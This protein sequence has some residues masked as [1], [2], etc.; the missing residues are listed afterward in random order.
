MPY[1]KFFSAPQFQNHYYRGYGNIYDNS[2]P[3]LTEAFF[4]YLW[5]ATCLFQ[6]E[7]NFLKKKRLLIHI[8]TCMEHFTNS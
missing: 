6:N 1:V 3:L 7:E 5:K 2:E 8:P 4:T